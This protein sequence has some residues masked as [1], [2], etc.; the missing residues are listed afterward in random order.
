MR[1]D[2]LEMVKH[3]LYKP[4][5]YGEESRKAAQYTLHKIMDVLLRLL[6]PFIPH[7]SDEIWMSVMKEGLASTSSW[8]EA[9][10]EFIDED[11]EK[12]GLLAKKLVADVRK[13]KSDN[14]LSLGSELEYVELKAS[15]ALLKD[16]EKISEDVK[17]TGKI[18]E[19]K[20]TLA[21]VEEYELS[22]KK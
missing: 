13:Y 19:L 6:S 21:E 1:D 17:G 8:P 15:E 20:T 12:L 4:E 11:S 7:I 3:R 16:F 5:I 14:N 18:K 2:Y 10:K 22:F 9:E